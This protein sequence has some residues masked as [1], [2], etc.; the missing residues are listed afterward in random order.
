MEQNDPANTGDN[1]QGSSVNGESSARERR[2]IRQVVFLDGKDISVRTPA[3]IGA[4]YKMLADLHFAVACYLASDGSFGLYDAGTDIK[5]REEI[6]RIV[7]PEAI[8]AIQEAIRGSSF[9]KAS[10]DKA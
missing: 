2:I 8:Q 5:A 6:M 3:A 9:A 10:A 1:M 4:E 7:S